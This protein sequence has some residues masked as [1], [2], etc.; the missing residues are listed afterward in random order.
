MGPQSSD[1]GTQIDKFLRDL[2]FNN[3]DF[4]IGH[5]KVWYTPIKWSCMIVYSIMLHLG[6]HERKAEA[7]SPGGAW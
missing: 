3:E 7:S 5:S 6:F 4:Q 1:L 2:N